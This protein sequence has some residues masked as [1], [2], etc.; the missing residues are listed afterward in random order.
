MQDNDFLAVEDHF[1]FLVDGLNDRDLKAYRQCKHTRPETAYK[2]RNFIVY[3]IIEGVMHE[4][5]RIIV[6]DFT[7]NGEHGASCFLISQNTK[8]SVSVGYAPTRLFDYP[9]FMWLPLHSKLRWGA[10]ETTLHQGSLAFPVVVRTRSR[11]G[12]REAGITYCE[13]GL[14]FGMEFDTT[15]AA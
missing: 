8:R 15:R 1:D 9:V 5:D 3:K 2:G 14:S 7:A 10:T 4:I 6:D 12:L 13:T 11:L